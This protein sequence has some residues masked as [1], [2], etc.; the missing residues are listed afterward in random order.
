MSSVIVRRFGCIVGCVVIAVSAAAA[1]GV[2][3]AAEPEPPAEVKTL[4]KE[5]VEAKR[6]GDAKLIGG[7]LADTF[8]GVGPLGA[9]E[10]K[11]A[12]VRRLADPKLK[13]TELGSREQ[14]L[15]S[16]GDVV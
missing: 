15:R 4:A 2:L 12:F 9:A 14:S 13:V 5:W 1:A 8:V 10:D 3:R 16:H 11:R 6:L 7:Y